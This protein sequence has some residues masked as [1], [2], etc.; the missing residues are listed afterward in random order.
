[1]APP[2]DGGATALSTP[3]LSP[4]G[5]RYHRS[6]V[7]EPAPLDPLPAYAV[8][9]ASVQTLQGAHPWPERVTREWALGGSTGAGAR[10]CVVDSG[11]EAGHPLVG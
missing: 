11:I 10:V 9:R 6:A 2:A 4:H 3:P 8:D 1:M 7:T 5:V